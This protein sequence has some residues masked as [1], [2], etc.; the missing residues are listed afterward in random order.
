MNIK[1]MI[2][3]LGVAASGLLMVACADTDAQY[4][5]AEVDAPVLTG[6]TPS[7]DTLLTAGSQTIVL[8]FDKNVFFA[9]SNAS[10]ITLNGESV[11]SALVYGSSN[12]L[13]I[14]ANVPSAETITLLVPEGLVMGPQQTPVVG[15]ITVVWEGREIKVSTG[16]ANANAN[17]EAQA[18]F[19][20]LYANYGSKMF[21]ATMADVNWNTDGAEEVYALTGHYPAFACFD[22]IHTP[23]SGQNWIN[24][25]DLT[26]VTDWADKGGK[27]ML[28]WHWIVPTNP[29]CA[30]EK[31]M[32]NDW[33]GYLQIVDDDALSILANAK[34]GDKIVVHYKDASGAQGSIK[35]SSWMG[36][37]DATSNYDYFD[38]GSGNYATFGSCIDDGTT[39]YTLTLD[40]TSAE[41]VKSG[42]IISGHDYTVTAVN[43]VPSGSDELTYQPDETSFDVAN[44]L[45]DGTIENKIMNRDLADIASRLS[46]LQD[47]NI[48]VLWRP[49][50]EAAG[51]TEKYTGGTAWFW[52]GAAGADTYK[53][54]WQYM[55]TYFQEQGVNNLVWVFTCDEDDYNWYPGDEYVDLV[56]ADIYNVSS[57]T[58]IATQFE[59]M[60]NLYPNKMVALS[61]CGAVP[62]VTDMFDAGAKWS[63]FMPWSGDY[64]DGVPMASDDW[65]TTAMQSDLVIKLDDL[66]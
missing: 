6:V 11:E 4:T 39:S 31:T 62:T 46:A 37:D 8:S 21:S 38:I 15:D 42:I 60:Q 2:K 57:T 44:I 36:I 26:P 22:Y 27:V 25:D 63:Y 65:W 33:S 34:S 17:S 24:Y 64:S 10:L 41:A 47:E 50:H 19:D 66:Q 9:S 51:N 3:S 53:Q 12:E 16:L 61:E 20:L 28:M 56:G 58:T 40:D 13:T 49:L 48:A 29:L 32:P 30:D 45:T 14:T 52:W 1:H 18:L 43:F 59:D 55:F 54:L 7:T 35:N 5:I 23:Y